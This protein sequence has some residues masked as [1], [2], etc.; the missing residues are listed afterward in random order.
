MRRSSFAI[1]YVVCI[2][3]HTSALEFGVAE[4]PC[5]L[6]LPQSVGAKS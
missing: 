1:V 2:G 6:R 4:S 5:V 3:V